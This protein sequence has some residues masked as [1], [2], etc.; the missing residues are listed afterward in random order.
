M[1]DWT[2]LQ[3]DFDSRN[4]ISSALLTK[5]L[6]CLWIF[7]LHFVLS[8]LVLDVCLSQQVFSVVLQ[9][10]M[11]ITFMTEKGAHMM[12]ITYKYWSVLCCLDV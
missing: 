12:E 11:T 3:R 9:I 2:A 7:D 5:Q 10:N 1:N 8:V 6:C 4:S